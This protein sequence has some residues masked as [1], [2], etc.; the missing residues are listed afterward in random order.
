MYWKA[1]D[2]PPPPVPEVIEDGDENAE[3]ALVVREDVVADI[4]K[5]MLWRQALD[6]FAFPGLDEEKMA[7]VHYWAMQKGANAFQS[8]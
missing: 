4:D 6:H 2:A 1:V 7:D 8:F 3:Q 5:D